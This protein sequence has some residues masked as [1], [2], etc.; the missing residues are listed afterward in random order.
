MQ[1]AKVVPLRD[2]S[3]APSPKGGAIPKR[4]KWGWS[5]LPATGEFMWL[6][7]EELHIDRRYQRDPSETKYRQIARN[8]DWMLCG[9]LRVV[10][11][12]DGVAVII[13][14]QNRA[15]A[16]EMRDDITTLPCIVFEWDSLS[17]EARAFIDANTMQTSVGPFDRHRAG[18]VAEDPIALKAEEVVRSVGYEF[19]SSSPSGKATSAVA[20]VHAMVERDPD[21]ARQVFELAADAAD[22]N[23]VFATVLMGLFYVAERDEGLFNPHFRSKVVEIGHDALLR[24]YQQERLTVGK[25]GARIAGHAYVRLLNKGQRGRFLSLDRDFE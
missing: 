17:K 10:L 20:R 7:K 5:D 11:R 21:L 9:A 3:L 4:E 2:R 8:W 19:V 25:G 24:T 12:P 14:G 22:E 18:L 13:D 15:L 6:P 23:P 16:A 1:D